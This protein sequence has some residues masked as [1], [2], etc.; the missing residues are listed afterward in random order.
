MRYFLCLLGLCFLAFSSVQRAHL[1]KAKA[2]PPV[3]KV[4]RVAV[5]GSEPFVVKKGSDFEGI[6]VEIWQAVAAQVGWRYRFQTYE[7]VPE[8][9]T[10]VT[11]GEA[12]LIV[13]PVS[14]TAAR[15]QRVRFTEPYFRSSLS[16]LSHVDAPSI[17]EMIKPF[18]IR[19]FFVAVAILS[20]T[21][22][23]VGTLIWLAERNESSDEF[24]RR[25]G[26]GIANGIWLAI[27]TMT[28]VGYGDRAPKTVL[29]RVVTAVW[30][31]VSI[32]T[33]TSLVAGIASTLTLTGMKTVA[34]SS[35]AELPGK[36]VAVLDDSPGQDLALYSDAKTQPVESVQKGYDLVKQQKVDAFVFDRPQLLYLLQ[37][38]HTSDL[39]VSKAQY[40]YQGYGFA[41][42][43]ESPVIHDLNINLLQLQESGRVKRI[44]REWLGEAE[45]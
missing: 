23:L 13:G 41:A 31:I 30:M 19:S 4:L 28:T 33:A 2:A 1:A 5:A 26:P 32:I 11:D 17:W 8:A 27:V 37:Q 10:A 44:I 24:P 34:I 35:T 20:F 40:M 22:A 3:T 14:I 6:S 43:L 12:D 18:F 36:L 42:P 21:L 29:G 45:Q 25:A 16:I 7:S 9:L 39:A 15:A 38:E